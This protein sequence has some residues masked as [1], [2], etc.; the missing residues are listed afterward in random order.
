L[1]ANLTCEPNPLVAPLHPKAVPVSLPEADYSD[2]LTGDWEKTQALACPY[3]SQ[4]ME[5]A[6]PAK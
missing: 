1:R 2:W 5:V 3:P 4:L 6:S